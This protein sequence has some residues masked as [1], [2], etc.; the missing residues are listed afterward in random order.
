MKS[1]REE[2]NKIRNTPTV[3]TYFREAG[4]YAGEITT[5]TDKIA[6]CVAAEDILLEACLRISGGDILTANKAMKQMIQNVQKNILLLN[7]I[8]K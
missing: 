2:A 3:I 8:K 5:E 1:I 6:L 7:T 4:A